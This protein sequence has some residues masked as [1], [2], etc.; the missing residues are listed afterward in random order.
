MNFIHKLV[1]L[2]EQM[3]PDKPFKCLCTGCGLIMRSNNPFELELTAENHQ[4]KDCPAF[5]R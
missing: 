5:Q 4:K 3:N 1:E 2:Y